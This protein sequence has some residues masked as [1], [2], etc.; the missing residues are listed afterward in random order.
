[1]WT[2]RLTASAHKTHS[3]KSIGIQNAYEYAGTLNA[4]QKGVGCMGKGCAVAA[5]EITA[6]YINGA[7]GSS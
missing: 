1:M 5:I 3:E 6:Q 2:K 4:A 7:K